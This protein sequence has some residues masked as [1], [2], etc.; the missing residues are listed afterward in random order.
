VG[1]DVSAVAKSESVNGKGRIA[2]ASEGIAI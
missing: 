1:L 2:S